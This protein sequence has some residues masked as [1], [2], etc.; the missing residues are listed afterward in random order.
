MNDSSNESSAVGESIQFSKDMGIVHRDLFR[1]LPAAVGEH[2]YEVQGRRVLITI[3]EGQIEIS[4]GEQRE[5]RIA[6]LRLP[7]TTVTFT[8]HNLAEDVLNRFM[9][10]FD[11]YFRRGGG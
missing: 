6:L 10:R 11:L 3:G 8:V 5:R 7:V 1:S 9:E 2:D 4:L